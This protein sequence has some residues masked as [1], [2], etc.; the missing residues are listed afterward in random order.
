M[1]RDLTVSVVDAS[2]AGGGRKVGELQVPVSP[3][4]QPDLWQL[5]ERTHAQLLELDREPSLDRCDAMVRALAEVTTQVHR[6]R[7][8][9]QGK[10]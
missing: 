7:M 8:R 6:L 4:L 10:R 3:L 9:L 5:A 1:N 2:R